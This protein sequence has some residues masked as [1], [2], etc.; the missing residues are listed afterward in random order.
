MVNFIKRFQFARNL[1]TLTSAL[2]ELFAEE[3]QVLRRSLVLQQNTASTLHDKM[4]SEVSPSCPS[5]RRACL[6]LLGPRKNQRLYKLR[7]SHHAHSRTLSGH[8][9]TGELSRAAA[10]QRLHSTCHKS[11]AL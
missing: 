10:P 7:S 1:E 8:R 9:L 4:K 5:L 11:L 6:L 2:K 3:D